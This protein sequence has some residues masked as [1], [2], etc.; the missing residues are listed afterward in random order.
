MLAG[1]V[2]GALGTAVLTVFQK[3]SLEGTRL[4]ED[5][6]ATHHKY[7]KQQSELSR[8]FEQAHVKAVESLAEAVGTELPPEHRKAAAPAMEFAFGIVCA[9]L[10][11]AAAEYLPVVTAGFGGVYGAVLFAGASEVV[12]PAI[13]FVAPPQNRTPV[14]H[15]GGLSGNVVYGVVT[16]V[17]RR[18]L[19]G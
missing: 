4:A 5:H 16:E 8:S 18:S 1:A 7:T 13:G 14:Q 15:V 17:V 2:G 11:G 3:G 6:T 12:L 10:Y 9:A 19:R